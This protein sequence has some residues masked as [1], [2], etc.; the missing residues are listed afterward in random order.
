[1]KRTSLKKTG[2]CVVLAV[3]VLSITTVV[4]TAYAQ[5]PP[6]A[7]TYVQ[8]GPWAFASWYTPTACGFHAIDVGILTISTFGSP[9]GTGQTGPT[10]NQFY[11]FVQDTTYSCTGAYTIIVG[12]FSPSDPSS[13]FQFAEDRQLTSARLTGTT[14]N[15]QVCGWDPAT[16]QYNCDSGTHQIAFDVQWTAI[17]TQFFGTNNYRYTSSNGMSLG[18]SVGSQSDA[19]VSGS[20][21]EDGTNVISAV[22]WAYSGGTLGN[23]INGFVS[24]IRPSR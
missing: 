14:S 20:I 15:V 13:T 22:N 24:V 7:Q 12:D 2:Q 5:T 16:G 6:Y 11:G 19:S 18:R 10:L 1:M 17:G 9:S 4:P 3:I 21:L 8:K 23:S